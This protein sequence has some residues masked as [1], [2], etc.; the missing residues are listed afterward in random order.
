MGKNRMRLVAIFFLAFYA[1]GVPLPALL[2]ATAAVAAALIFAGADPFLAYYLA[3]TLLA[4]PIPFLV[5]RAGR[6]IAAFR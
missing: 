5:L 4:A 1:F 2:I 6:R 3:A